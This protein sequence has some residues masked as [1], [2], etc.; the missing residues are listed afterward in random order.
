MQLAAVAAS[1]ADVSLSSVIYLSQ[2]IE[3]IVC[4]ESDTAKDAVRQLHSDNSF[5]TS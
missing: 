5:I 1:V 3:N 2:G 4:F